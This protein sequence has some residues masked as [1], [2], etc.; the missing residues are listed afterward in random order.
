MTVAADPAPDAIELEI[1]DAKNRLGRIGPPPP[2]RTQPRDEFGKGERLDQVVVCAGVESSN[3]FFK[4]TVRSQDQN[5]RDI[6][7]CADFAEE[8]KPVF[9]RQSKVEHD[10]IELPVFDRSLRGL[11]A[12]R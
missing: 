8:L 9:S 1:A 3:A 11:G 6:A 10:S 5:G 2:Q 12:A 7:N 4:R